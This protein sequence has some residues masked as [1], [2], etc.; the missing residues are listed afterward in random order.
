M[1]F[2]TEK[3]NSA[4]VFSKIL[5]RPS[6]ISWQ[7]GNSHKPLPISNM[8]LPDWTHALFNNWPQTSEY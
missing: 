3:L 5:S 6:Q 8:F 1:L 2:S 7:M 4:Q